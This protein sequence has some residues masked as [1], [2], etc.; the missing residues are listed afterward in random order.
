MKLLI[1][2]D[3]E[4]TSGVTTWDQVTPG[5]TEWQ[6]FRRIMTADV[7]AA[8]AGAF[9]GGAD[10]VVVS[11][12]HWN[13]DNL[14]I[15]ELDRRARL[16]T[17]SPSPFSMVQ[18]LGEGVDAAFFVGYHARNGTQNAILDHTWSAARVHN[19]F[20]NGRVSGEIGLNGSLCG[21]F[22]VPVLLVS[23]DQTACA[24]AREW[25][26]AVETVTTKTAHGR[27]AAEVL[28]PALV[29]ERLRAGAENALRRFFKGEGPRPLVAQTPV[30]LG[31]EL[32]GSDMGDKAALFPGIRR[33]D[34]RTVEYTAADMPTAYQAMR[35]A[36]MLALRA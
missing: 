6:R 17:G 16:N 33:L 28:P 21:H 13:G 27:W 15:E 22:G 18:G 12:G 8:I 1:A 9:A 7:N 14:L 31:L 3:M 23:G 24:E 36:I 20:I 30:T 4:G 2:V 32:V 29:Q 35:T 5:H 25:I 34:G 19:L 26:D 11:D 10:E